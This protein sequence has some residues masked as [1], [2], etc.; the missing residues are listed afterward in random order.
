MDTVELK[1]TTYFLRD[2]GD[3]FAKTGQISPFDKCVAQKK[4]R[5]SEPMLK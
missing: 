4:V 5:G 1:D 3:I 2:F